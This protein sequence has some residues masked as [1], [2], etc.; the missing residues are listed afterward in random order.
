[1]KTLIVYASSHGTTEKVAGLIAKGIGNGIQVSNL[2][3][4]KKIDVDFYDQIIIGGSI[5]AG[6][7]QK[8][9][10]EFCN[11]NLSILIEKRIALFMCG[12]NNAELENEFNN[13]F[14]EQLRNMSISNKMVGGEYLVDKMNFLEKVIIKKIAKVTESASLLNYERI[15]EL[16]KD[17]SIN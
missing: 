17:V 6:F 8:K 9:V 3:K 16:V 12:L 1:M 10:K 7:M 4:S 13:G 15:D 14:P 5:H 11:N 2:K